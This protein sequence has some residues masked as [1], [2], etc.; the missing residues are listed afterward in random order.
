M[1]SSVSLP[2]VSFRE[3]CQ[4]L[5]FPPNGLPA[6]NRVSPVVGLLPLAS[7]PARLGIAF[8]SFLVKQFYRCDPVVI[9]SFVITGYTARK[10]EWLLCSVGYDITHHYFL[11]R[12]NMSYR[13]TV[14]VKETPCI[15]LWTLV[16]CPNGITR[17]FDVWEQVGKGSKRL[18]LD[19][20]LCTSLLVR[21]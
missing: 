20:A 8:P 15:L 1:W 5:K 21:S 10:F 17:L 3:T 13:I 11:Y 2:W 16:S 18:V 7:G 4:W 19:F 14:G 12:N 6:L 9:S